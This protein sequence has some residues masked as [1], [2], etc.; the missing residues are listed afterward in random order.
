MEEVK[1]N[2]D[3]KN[4]QIEALQVVQNY[5][6]RLAKGIRN[7]LP[8]LRGEEREDTK[9]YLKQ[10]INGLNFTLEAIN[11]TM[12]LL[13]ETRQRI[14][15]EKTNAKVEKLGAALKKK[16]NAEIADVLEKEILPFVEEFLESATEVLE[17][18]NA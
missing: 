7:I 6:I 11:G 15:K 4:E 3:Y 1:T 18:Q 10:I 5:D 17:E 14:D 2:R 13:N 12:S 16:E 9:E 8:E